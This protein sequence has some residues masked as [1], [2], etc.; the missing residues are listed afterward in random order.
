[1]QRDVRDGWRKNVFNEVKRPLVIFGTGGL[2]REIY[3]VVQD[4]S[5]HCAEPIEVV[6]FLDDNEIRHGQ[7]VHDLPVLGGVEWLRSYPG[8]AT[9]IAVGSPAVRRRIALRATAAGATFPV[10]VHPTATIGRRVALG[11]GTVVCA[12]CVLA[13]DIEVGPFALFNFQT[14][15]GHDGVVGAYATLSPGVRVSG[16]VRIDEGADIGTGATFIQGIAVG[17]WSIVGAGAVV[18]R[19]VP[20]NATVVGVPAHVIKERPPAWHEAENVVTAIVEPALL[21]TDA[22]RKGA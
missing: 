6:G 22:I 5:A 11:E 10:L 16:N 18:T 9:I 14:T 13:T 20:P 17:A 4:V 2:A 7:C 3:E 1:M 21:S 19:D 15:V 12:G 8:T